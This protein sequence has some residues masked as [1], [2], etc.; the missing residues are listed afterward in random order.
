MIFTII[1]NHIAIGIFNQPKISIAIE[2]I[3][4]PVCCRVNYPVRI[5][6]NAD[7]YNGVCGFSR[8][9][10]WIRI[11]VFGLYILCYINSVNQ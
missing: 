3:T 10:K 1:P 9:Y 7:N 2:I 6:S 8:F 4:C 5:T 11:R